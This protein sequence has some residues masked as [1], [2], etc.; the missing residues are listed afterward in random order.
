VNEDAI[1]RETKE[2]QRLRGQDSAGI[3]VKVRAF[4]SFHPFFHRETYIL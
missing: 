3:L 1:E 2:S 4:S